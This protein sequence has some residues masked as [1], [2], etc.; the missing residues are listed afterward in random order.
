MIVPDMEGMNSLLDDSDATGGS[1]GNPIYQ[2]C[3]C[4]SSGSEQ[5]FELIKGPVGCMIQCRPSEWGDF[6][7]SIVSIFRLTTLTFLTPFCG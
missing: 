5:N 1:G 3:G 4:L 7:T 2:F 6:P